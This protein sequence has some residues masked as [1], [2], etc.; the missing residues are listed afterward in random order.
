MSDPS[1]TWEHDLPFTRIN[2]P[3]E[4]QRLPPDILAALKPS[5]GGSLQL[6]GNGHARG[7]R[8]PDDFHANNLLDDVVTSQLIRLTPSWTAT[9]DQPE[10]ELQGKLVRSFQTW[11]DAPPLPWHSYYDWNFH[12]EPE[13][14]F[15]WLRGAANTASRTGIFEYD[16]G[17]FHRN[18]T[19]QAGVPGHCMECEWDAGTFGLPGDARPGPMFDKDWAWPMANQRVWLVG[20]S[21][22]DGGHETHGNPQ[23]CRSELHPVK[24]VATARWEAFA[25]KENNKGKE[26]G[27]VHT[28]AIQFMFFSSKFGGYNDFDTLKPKD[29]KPYEFIVDLPEAP[30]ATAPHAIGHTPDFPVNTVM[31][32]KLELLKH[33]ERDR[34]KNARSGAA[35]VDPTVDLLPLADGGDPKRRQAKVTIPLAALE[36]DYYGVIISLG[37]RDPTGELAAKVKKVTVRFDNLFKASINHDVFKEEWRFKA[38][39]NGRWFQWE[40]MGVSNNSNHSLASDQKG[41]PARIEL[42]LHEDEFVQISAHGAELN[43]VDD[44]YQRPDPGR[45]VTITPAD[46]QFEALEGTTILQPELAS[47]GATPG[48]LRWF[49]QVEVKPLRNGETYPVQRAIARAIRDLMW[50]TFN[51][52]NSPLGLIDARVHQPDRERLLNPF[53]IKQHVNKGEQTIELCGYETYE[54]GDSAELLERPHT[55]DDHASNPDWLDY[56][57]RVKITVEDQKI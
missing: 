29:G 15:T 16:P 9:L 51:D 1:K 42:F 38:G 23:L 27:D 28:P 36:R 4:V 26:K 8:R 20:R 31:V 52:Q 37:W 6:D 13:A 19:S 43:L 50:T 45:T 30:V 5:A 21:I 56:R 10:Q 44:V 22:Y 57:V 41:R 14:P 47:V 49:S 55:S 35:V 40:F 24:A 25:F 48:P 33:F 46:V 7:T 53:F 34:F 32:R 39:V 17:F 18:K 11:T 54:E 3:S 12:V 2:S